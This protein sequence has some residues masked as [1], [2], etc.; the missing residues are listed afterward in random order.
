MTVSEEY[1]TGHTAPF[2]DKDICPDNLAMAELLVAGIKE[3]LTF[4]ACLK[5]GC[6]L[7]FSSALPVVSRHN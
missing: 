1:F 3:N 7:F 2:G 4:D 6:S 5:K